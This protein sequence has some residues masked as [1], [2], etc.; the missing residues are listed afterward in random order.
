ML[1]RHQ[2]GWADLKWTQE[3]RLQLTGSSWSLTGNIVLQVQQNGSLHLKQLPSQTRGV[4]EREWVVDATRKI[5]NGWKV[6]IDPA[7]DLLVI[8]EKRYWSVFQ[9]HL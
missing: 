3:M 9:I 1:E 8:V 4:E 2:R 5:S 7:Q 6:R